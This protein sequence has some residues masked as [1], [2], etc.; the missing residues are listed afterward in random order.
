[1]NPSNRKGNGNGKTLLGKAGGAPVPPP[2]RAVKGGGAKK[3]AVLRIALDSGQYRVE[4][5]KI[6]DKMAKDAVREIRSRHR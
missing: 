5:K 4:S 2:V 1:V 3:V 6:A